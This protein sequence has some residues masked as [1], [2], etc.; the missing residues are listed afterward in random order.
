MDGLEEKKEKRIKLPEEF[1]KKNTYLVVLF[2]VAA[3][4]IFIVSYGILWCMAFVV[5]VCGLSCPEACGI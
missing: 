4:G 1:I 3:H 5:V 2:L